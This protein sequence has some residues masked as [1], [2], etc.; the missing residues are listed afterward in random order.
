[1]YLAKRLLVTLL[2]GAF[3]LNANADSFESNFDKHFKVKRDDQGKLIAVKARMV[4]F[5]FNMKDFV[6]RI[7]N[8]LKDEQLKQIMKGKQYNVELEEM[9][10]EFGFENKSDQ[11]DVAHVIRE[12]L[13][14]LAG[15]DVDESF[16]IIEK[17]GFFTEFAAK[18]RQA[19]LNFDLS[20]IA[21]PNNSRFFY[22]KKATY[23][24]VTWALDFARKRFSSIPILNA[25]SYVIVKVEKLIREQREYYQNMLLHYLHR[26]EDRLGFT[27]EE[28]DHIFSSIYEARISWTGLMESNRAAD[29]WDR[30]GTNKFFLA[31]RTSNNRFRNARWNYR[32]VGPKASYA[33]ATVTGEKGKM[34]INLV[35][36]KH[37]LSSAP[38]VA[39][40]FEKPKKIMRTRLLIQIVEM[41]ISFVPVGDGLK[42]IFNNFAKSFY[43]KQKI[44]E[45][46]LVAY[47]DLAGE[48]ELAQKMVNQ[49]LN[50]FLMVK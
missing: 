43:E 46:A 32:S 4:S 18:L 48:D 39:Y 22:R 12:V 35:N 30:Y 24:V 5:K 16:G 28:A 44:T 6:E 47:L 7:K 14:G 40:Y 15:V 17:T 26:Y 9:I 21:N 1:M 45:G 10:N 34:I 2:L 33:F 50:P 38:A 25:A 13:N 3:A 36:N 49:T 27:K 8:D 41:A 20:V 37:M 19:L 42:N 23:R 11:D 31:L 29:T